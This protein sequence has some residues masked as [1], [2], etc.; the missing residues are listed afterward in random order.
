MVSAHLENASVFRTAKGGGPAPSQPAV[1]VL[2]RR[3]DFHQKDF[4]R[5]ARDLVRLGEQGKLRKTKPERPKVYDRKTGKSRS[6]T[7]IYRDRVIR[8][9][10]RDDRKYQK[11]KTLVQRL[12]GG[13]GPVSGPNQGLDPDHIHEL[14]LGG[15]DTYDNFRLMD[16][17]TNRELGREISRALNDVPIGTPVTVKVIP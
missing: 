5:K 15:S 7:N 17:W 8:K 14:Q 13:K 2:R 3:P 6:K 1:V 4:D 9:L 12:Y 16:S 11:N 10:T